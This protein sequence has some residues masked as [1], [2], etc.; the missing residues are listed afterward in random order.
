MTPCVAIA[1]RRSSSGDGLRHRRRRVGQPPQHA[2]RHDHE[3]HDAEP[4]VQDEEPV[5]RPLLEGGRDH[6][7]SRRD[8]HK[9]EEHDRP[10]EE[11]GADAETVRH[12]PSFVE[13][14]A[15]AELSSLYARTNHSRNS[16]IRRGEPFGS[17]KPP[18]WNP[19]SRKGSSRAGSRAITCT[20]T[21]GP[22]ATPAS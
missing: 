4:L 9:Q 19:H 2:G 5:D 11:P 14:A 12:Q 8:L 17:G 15:E 16:S 18:G 13:R 1:M 10:V 7:D 22:F 3:Q 20:G 6:R 21:S